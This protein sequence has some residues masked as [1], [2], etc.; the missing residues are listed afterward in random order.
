MIKQAL[1]TAAVAAAL[2]TLLGLAMPAT[3][4]AAAAR[5]EGPEVGG[6]Q[7]APAG[8]WQSLADLWDGVVAAVFGGSEDEGTE[9]DETGASPEDG[10]EDTES[11]GDDGPGVDPDG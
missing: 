5:V 7:T 2:G 9:A 1:R 3:S 4:H 11:E 8:L 10:G 6:D